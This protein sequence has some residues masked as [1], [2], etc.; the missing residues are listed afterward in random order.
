MFWTS[1]PYREC[2]ELPRKIASSSQIL[3]FLPVR[4]DLLKEETV[5]QL[6]VIVKTT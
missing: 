2:L 4:F 6:M 5:G 3:K 1:S